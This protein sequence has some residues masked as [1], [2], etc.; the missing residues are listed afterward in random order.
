M[1]NI[2]TPKWLRDMK[3]PIIK[4]HD[5]TIVYCNTFCYF[6]LNRHTRQGH[7]YLWSFRDLSSP[8]AY[9]KNLSWRQA[10]NLVREALYKTISNG[11]VALKG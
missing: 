4:V 3:F 10:R 6:H 11:G 8:G 2:R 7:Q 9:Y 1:K 5:G